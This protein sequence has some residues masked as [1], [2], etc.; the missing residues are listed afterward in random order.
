MNFTESY[1]E[2]ALA[3]LPLFHSYGLCILALHKLSA[4]LKI[5]TLPKFQPDTFLNALLKYHI[6]LLYAA[7]PMGKYDELKFDNRT[8]RFTGIGFT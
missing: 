4:G 5:V 3:V 1:Q 2:S 6:N 8:N 7:P